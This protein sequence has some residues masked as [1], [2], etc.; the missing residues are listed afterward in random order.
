MLLFVKRL[1]A[2]AMIGPSTLHDFVFQVVALLSV[3]FRFPRAFWDSRWRREHRIKKK[4][5]VRVSVNDPCVEERKR[6]PLRQSAAFSW[7]R[8]LHRKQAR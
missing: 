3:C 7:E 8:S 4:T 1:K 6:C 5:L 2:T